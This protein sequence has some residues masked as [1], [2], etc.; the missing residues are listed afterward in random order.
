MRDVNN[1]WLIRY[2]HSNTASAFFFLVYLHMGRGLYYGSYRAPRT[3]VWTLGV[4][5]FLLMIITGFLGLLHSPKWFKSN[6]NNNNNNKNN[7]NNNN[8]GGYDN[9]DNNNHNN[10]Y[11]WLSKSNT[12]PNTPLYKGSVRHFSTFTRAL[13]TEP[14]KPNNSYPTEAYSKEV[15]EFLGKNNIE[16]VY[17]YENLG[18]KSIQSKVLNDTRNLAGVYLILNKVNLGCY[19]GS[20][21]TGRFNTRFRR[22]LFNFQGSKIVKA[23]V[24]KY[25]IDNFAFIILEIFAEIVNKENNKQLLDMEDYY[26]KSLLPDYNIATEAGNTFGYKHTEMT[27]LKMVENYNPERRLW[28]GNLNRNKPMSEQHKENLR[29]AALIRVKPIYSEEAL[30]NMRKSSKPIIVYNLDKTV[31][32]KFPSITAG[33]LSLRCSVKTI[34]RA[35]NTPKK[36]LKRRWIVKFTQK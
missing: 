32:G 34:Y 8:N 5:I 17:V 27:R 12:T 23:A 30:A 22:H 35:M 1:G 25:K 28:I 24:K 11:K 3:L 7:N 18:D 13:N 9:N 15:I 2:L 33:A 29:K 19:V 21:S 36:I 20:A 10:N 4:V 6:N 26:I 14:T 16:P 31:Y